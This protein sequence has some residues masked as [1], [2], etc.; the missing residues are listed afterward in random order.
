MPVQKDKLRS[1]QEST[2]IPKGKKKVSQVK[3]FATIK[4]TKETKLHQYDSKNTLALV[5][6]N[7]MIPSTTNDNQRKN[8]MKKLLQKQVTRNLASIPHL[9]SRT[10]LKSVSKE[11]PAEKTEAEKPLQLGVSSIDSKLKQKV[12]KTDSK[13]FENPKHAIPENSYSFQSNSSE[14]MRDPKRLHEIQEIPKPIENGADFHGSFNTSQLITK[15][16]D[17]IDDIQELVRGQTGLSKDLLTKENGPLA[18]FKT[19]EIL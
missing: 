4:R 12:D 18:Y 11:A 17:E 1:R 7:K 16:R 2:L 10:G 8:R 3:S 14:E 19:P 6:G 5:P 9:G 15:K 13:I